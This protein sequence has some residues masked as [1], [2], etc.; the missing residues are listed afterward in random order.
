M[1]IIDTRRDS[2]YPFDHLS[3]ADGENERFT[4]IATGIE[5]LSVGFQGSL[6]RTTIENEVLR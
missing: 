1:R 2:A 3:R 5:F 6:E 4:S